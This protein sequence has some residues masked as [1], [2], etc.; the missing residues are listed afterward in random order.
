[1]ALKNKPDYDKAIIRAA[2]CCL[3]I[4]QFDK[5]VEYCDK[6]LFQQ[7]ENE[8]M[9]ELRQKAINIKK[10]Q[11]RDARKKEIEQKKKIAKEEKLINTVK[12]SVTRFDVSKSK[13]KSTGADFE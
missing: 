4:S 13:Y 2:N 7:S 1:M 9:L 10:N 8:E 11:E 12:S 5:C 6:I 3:H